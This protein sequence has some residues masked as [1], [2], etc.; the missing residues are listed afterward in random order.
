MAITLRI[1]ESQGHRQ[2]QTAPLRY[3]VFLIHRSCFRVIARSR[4]PHRAPCKLYGLSDPARCLRPLRAHK[5]RDLFPVEQDGVPRRVTGPSAPYPS[6]PSWLRGF[7]PSCL[8]R[9]PLP[10]GRGSDRSSRRRDSGS[11]CCGLYSAMSLR[12][13]G[14]SGLS[15]SER[16]QCSNARSRYSV[17]VLSSR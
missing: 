6:V 8:A 9:Y 17:R 12:I 10:Y 15:S 4:G 2:E 14:W 16:C 11:S 5:A 13:R 3:S 1:F 7:V